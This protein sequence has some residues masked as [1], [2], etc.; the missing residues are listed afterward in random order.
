MMRDY[1]TLYSTGERKFKSKLNEE[2]SQTY[3][4]SSVNLPSNQVKSLSNINVSVTEHLLSSSFVSSTLL[5]I[6]NPEKTS[7]SL[8]HHATLK[9]LDL[10]VT[11]L[12]TL[13]DKCSIK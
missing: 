2:L 1:K 3:P 7:S 8:H 9:S 12:S 13:L 10:I 5:K 4:L 6:S 11:E